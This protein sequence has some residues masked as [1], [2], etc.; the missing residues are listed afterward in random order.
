VLA[1]RQRSQPLPQQQQRQAS[2]PL[3]QQQQ[4]HNSSP[5][6]AGWYECPLYKTSARSGA[7]RSRGTSSALVMHLQLPAALDT[8]ASFWILQGTAA[9]CTADQ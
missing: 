4:R 2:S 6:Q 3:P 8:P 5:Q 9:V 1:S 7:L